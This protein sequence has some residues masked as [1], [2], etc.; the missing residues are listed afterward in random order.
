VIIKILLIAAAIGVGV[1]VLRE[2]G[3]R[4]QEALRR[5]SGL[6]VVLAG[7][8]AVLWPDLTTIAANAVGVGRGTDLVLYLLVTVF[9]YVAL[10]TAQKIHRLQHDIMVL[11]RELALVQPA[12]PG[13]DE[14]LRRP[15][16]D[17]AVGTAA[18]R[19][20]P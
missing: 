20:Q 4:Q 14:A 6:L 7:I 9:A 15:E 17:S 5:A 3:P 12:R 10:T 19:D 13:G 11:T 1:L 2:K 18:T 8:V 16:G